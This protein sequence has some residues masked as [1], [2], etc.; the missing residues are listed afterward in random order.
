MKPLLIILIVQNFAISKNYCQ[1]FTANDLVALS[2]LSSKS[3]DQYMNKK[4][5]S[6]HNSILDEDIAGTSFFEKV[7][8]KKRDSLASRSVDLYKKGD[9]K[10]FVLHTTSLNEF[11]EGQKQLMTAGFFY[12]NK[13]DLMTAVSM[14][15]QKRNVT[16]EAKK[17]MEDSIPVYNFILKKKELPAPS[18]IKHAEDLL[19]FTSHEYLA[20]FF[21]EKNVKKDLYYFSEKELKKCSVLF[22]NSSLQ[23]VFVWGDE[24]NFCNLSYVLVSN[25]LPTVSAAKFG[26]VLHNNLWELKNGIY[27]G[28]GI[29]ELLKLNENDFE[30]YGIH[31]ELA[32][33]VKPGNNGKVDFKRSAIIL[34]CSNCNDDRLFDK[35]TIRAL[36]IAGKNL[37][38]YVY[39]IILFFSPH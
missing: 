3:I 7:N 17:V 13:K 20:S 30:V 2:S 6:S 8:F 10:Y 29:K 34:S 23:A 28:M 15:Y 37:P 1:S 19:N 27:P 5:F 14:L 9:T 35:T 24:D 26:G 4:R 32:F 39:Y 38:V 25:V 33:M 21:G 18:A 11:I 36:D 31:S 12:D 22:G 16:I